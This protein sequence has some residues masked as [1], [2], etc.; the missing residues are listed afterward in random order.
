M[1]KDELKEFNKFIGDAMKKEGKK[2][3]LKVGDGREFLRC[4]R[5][6]GKVNP[7]GAFIVASYLVGK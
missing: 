5:A 6:Q 3:Q 7:R 4:L 2:S 1:T